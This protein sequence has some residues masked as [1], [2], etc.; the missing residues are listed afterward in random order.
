MSAVAESDIHAAEDLWCKPGEHPWSR[1]RQRGRKPDACPLHGG[2]GADTLDGEHVFTD[3]ALAQDQIL[4]ADGFK[5]PTFTELKTA[6]HK[7]G[8]EGIL[9]S[10]RHL[11]QSQYD[12]LAKMVKDWRPARKARR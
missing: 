6:L 9:E 5:D 1:E 8:P 7:T 12:N 10:A 2:P 3:E 11:P 4:R